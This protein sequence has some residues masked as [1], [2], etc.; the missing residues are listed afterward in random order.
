M[1]KHQFDS[2]IVDRRLELIKK[3]LKSKNAEYSYSASAFENFE[4]GVEL[5]MHDKKE[6]YAWEL[7]VKH[8]QSIKSILE[9]LNDRKN[10]SNELIEEKFGDAINYL[11]LLEG[12]LKERNGF[13][14][15]M[16]FDLVKE[17]KNEKAD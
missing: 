17:I 4:K 13:E 3:I 14:S 5:S 9:N 16:R 12:M 1:T 7:L 15:A 2:L 11:I 8:L 6:K 10:P